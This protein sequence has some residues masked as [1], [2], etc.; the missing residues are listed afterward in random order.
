MSSEIYF[1]QNDTPRKLWHGGEWNKNCL[2]AKSVLVKSK[3]KFIVRCCF[4]SSMCM[5]Y[6]NP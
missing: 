4:I 6:N 1:N 3:H 5:L 2:L